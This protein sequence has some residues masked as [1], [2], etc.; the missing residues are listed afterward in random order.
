VCAQSIIAT[1]GGVAAVCPFT[2]GATPA[3]CVPADAN[4]VRVEDGDFD[5][6]ELPRRAEATNESHERLFNVVE[7]GVHRRAACASKDAHASR[8]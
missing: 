3:D 5:W 2:D 6:C 1:D 7:D 8:S 4:M